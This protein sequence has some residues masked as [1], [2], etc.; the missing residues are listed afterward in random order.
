MPR[1]G[2]GF[3][4]LFVAPYLLTGLLYRSQTLWA[5][6]LRRYLSVP[7]KV[8]EPWAFDLT[9]F[10]VTDQGRVLTPSE[11]WRFHTHP[12]LDILSGVYYLFFILFLSLSLVSFG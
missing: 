11:W 5:D 4:S 12:V 10:G 6:A 1:Q 3:L 9:Y 2:P 8:L 7:V